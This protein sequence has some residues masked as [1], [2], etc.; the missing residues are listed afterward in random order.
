MKAEM[1]VLDVSVPTGFSPVTE[2]IDKVIAGND[3]IKRY[4]IAGRKVTF[5]I[6]DM[7]PGDKVSFS[8][9]VQALYPVTAKGVTSQAYSYYNPD[10]KAETLSQ[11][12]VVTQ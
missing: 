1:V 12:I 10:I 6:E 2:S 3:N 5:Y 9:Y 8:F 11:D 7:Q 4:D